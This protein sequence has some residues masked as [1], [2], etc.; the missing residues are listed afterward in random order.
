MWTLRSLLPVLRSFILKIFPPR[1]SLFRLLVYR[2]TMHELPTSIIS[3]SSSAFWAVL[4]TT[5][6]SWP[7]DQL[8]VLADLL[9]VLVCRVVFIQALIAWVWLNIIVL[10]IRHHLWPVAGIHTDIIF[11]FVY[12]VIVL[13]FVMM[14]AFLLHLTY[15]I[16]RWRCLFTVFLCL[17]GPHKIYI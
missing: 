3:D 1:N 9:W 15:F 12:I 10:L 4:L 17:Y 8:L 11:V 16:P 5:L 7:V 14:A 6:C 2:L 13:R